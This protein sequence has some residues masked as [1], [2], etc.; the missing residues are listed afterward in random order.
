MFFLVHE[1]QREEWKIGPHLQIKSGRGGG[2][3]G[4]GMVGPGARGDPGPLGLRFQLR[5]GGQGRRREGGESEACIVRITEL[6]LF[7]CQS[8]RDIK[9]KET[10]LSPW[11][12]QPGSAGAPRPHSSS[13]VSLLPKAERVKS[14]KKASK[15]EQPT[16][17]PTHRTT[18]RDTFTCKPSQTPNSPCSLCVHLGRG[19]WLLFPSPRRPHQAPYL[20]QEDA[21]VVLSLVVYLAQSPWLRGSLL[22]Q[23]HREAT[24]QVLSRVYNL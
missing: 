3:G 5:R 15:E 7:L 14:P 22:N 6:A 23:Q 8:P 20:T 2:A 13:I 18:S 4:P 1:H 17:R 10:T 24:F 9:G 11:P 16:V 21:T 19:L 12:S